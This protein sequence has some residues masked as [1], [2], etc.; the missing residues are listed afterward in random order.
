MRPSAQ[1]RGPWLTR[2]IFVPFRD[3]PFSTDF[4]QEYCGL[5]GLTAGKI[6]PIVSGRQ[7]IPDYD[8]VGKVPKGMEWRGGYGL[9]NAM[10]L[11]EKSP[12]E[13]L[14]GLLATFNPDHDTKPT[15]DN[16]ICE[17]A[18]LRGNEDMQLVC[19]L[20][21]F[22]LPNFYATARAQLARLEEA[23]EPSADMPVFHEV[24]ERLKRATEQAK[25]WAG[26]HYHNLESDMEDRSRTGK[27]KLSELD[28]AICQWLEL[29]PPK[30]RT[31]LAVP[32]IPSPPAQNVSP[33]VQHPRCGAFVN[34]VN[35][36]PPEICH[37]CGAPFNAEPDMSGKQASREER[38][39][40]LQD[41][42]RARNK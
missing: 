18:V 20:Q 11:K 23:L 2:Y 40:R 32:A 16:G 41:E 17:I 8:Q 37:V 7:L 13:M 36:N 15:Q 10:K 14:E 24:A 26:W 42:S 19:D 9:G 3:R 28:D 38:T 30:F 27:S 29:A 1:D 39:T 33:Q 35:G 4:I 21:Q 6:T 5:E 22:C 31:L 34:V 25:I 12:Y